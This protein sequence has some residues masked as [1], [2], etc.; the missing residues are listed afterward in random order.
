MKTLVCLAMIVVLIHPFIDTAHAQGANS[1]KEDVLARILN[2]V[3]FQHSDLGYEPKGHWN[4]FPLDIPHRLTS[5]DDLFAEPLK[6]YDYATTMGNAVEIYLDPAYADSTDNGLY[7][8]LYH[9]GVDRKLG[10]F[11]SYSANLVPPPDTEEPLV[12]AFERLYVM[13]GAQTDFYTFGSKAD[14]PTV[15]EKVRSR[16]EKFPD[17]VK[18]I[19]AELIVNLADAIK[20]RDLAFRKCSLQDMQS[21]IAI[22]DLAAT[23]G[24][25][26]VYY[27]ELDD[28][29]DGIDFSSLHYAALKTAAATEK[30]ERQLIHFVEQIPDDF[31]C[32]IETPYGKVAIFSPINV[33]KRLPHEFFSTVL[34]SHSDWMVYDATNTLCIIDFG[35]KSI[36][37]GTAGAAI[38]LAN[39]VSVLIDLGG[40]RLLRL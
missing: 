29:A 38:T 27:P 28:I 33:K 3:G 12:T 2:E 30:A 5:F 35:R 18:T 13:A 11:R 21:A 40:G 9:L 1:E 8:L 39:P 23:Q 24:D 10:S 36:W 31:E 25:G 16:T 15:R 19:I 6:L 7:K 22:R 26:Q 14:L 37:M 4:R 17:S 20:W 34:A 32:E